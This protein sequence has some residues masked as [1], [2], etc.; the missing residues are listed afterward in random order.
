MS[1]KDKQDKSEVAPQKTADAAS[2]D[3]DELIIIRDGQ[4]VEID[5]GLPQEDGAD[6]AAAA[7]LREAERSSSQQ[8]LEAGPDDNGSYYDED[9]LEGSTGWTQRIVIFL[10]IIAVIVLAVFLIKYWF[11]S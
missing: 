7:P 4:T 8:S 1:A 9:E 5:E 3:E 2:P 11:F 10:V 6:R